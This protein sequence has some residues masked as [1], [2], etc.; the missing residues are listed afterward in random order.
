MGKTNIHTRT[1]QHT[2]TNTRKMFNVHNRAK[3]DLSLK[4][5]L[6]TRRGLRP[7]EIQGEFG[8]EAR[9]IHPDQNTITARIH[10]GCDARPPIPIPPELTARLQAHITRKNLKPTD[11]L[12]GGNSR[13]YGEAFRRFRNNLAKKLN[14]PTIK[15][16][17]LYDIRHAYCTKQLKRTQNTEIVRQIMGHKHL[18][19][20]QKY[21]HLQGFGNADWIV[22]GTNDKE[23]A[24]QLL[25]EDFQYQLTTPDGTMIFRKPK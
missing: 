9:D 12:F 5:D 22:E 19:T 7:C 18:N 6:S 10:K 16:I 21:L 1:D 4:I 23:R 20:T 8:L 24:K 3:G 17:R 25:K 2:A 14:D 11:R 15:S 13:R